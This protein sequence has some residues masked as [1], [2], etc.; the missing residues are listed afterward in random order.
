MDEI[1]ARQVQYASF[2]VRVWRNAEAAPDGSRSEWHGEVEHI[3]SGRR[4]AF[5]SLGELREL[6]CK[7]L[8]AATRSESTGSL[9]CREFVDSDLIDS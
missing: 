3:Q 1:E 9:A 2:L 5:A 8:P 4:T 7:P 6:L